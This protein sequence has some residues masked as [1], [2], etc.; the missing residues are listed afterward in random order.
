MLRQ[1]QH[2]SAYRLSVP[3][4]FANEFSLAGK[5]AIFVQG[6]VLA[7][8]RP[9]IAAWSDWYPDILPLSSLHGLATGCPRK[10]SFGLGLDVIC[11][12]HL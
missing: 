7:M 11:L 4:I 3:A 12:L 2:Y 10:S 1:R 5:V 6:L 9:H 8:G